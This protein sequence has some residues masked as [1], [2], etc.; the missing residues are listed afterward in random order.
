LVLTLL[1]CIGCSTRNK[2]PQWEP[3]RKQR[4]FTIATRQLPPQP[5]YGRT[6]WVRP[7]QVLPARKL[8]VPSAPLIM[9]IIE[10]EVKGR[11]L[12]EVALI[13]AATA[14]YRSY[15]A[16]SIASQK[17]SLTSLGTMEELALEIEELARIKVIIDHRQ[18]EV[19]FLSKDTIVPKIQE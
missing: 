6:R 12:S 1:I 8:E 15:C 9:P 7:P 11:P 19:R 18:K 3:G 10:F 5:V 2:E 4:V 16:S 13:L 17:L 14:G